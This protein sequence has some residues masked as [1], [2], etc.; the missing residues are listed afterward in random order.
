MNEQ[1]IKRVHYLARLLFLWA[2]LIAG[3][4]IQLQ[5]FQHDDYKRQA[6]NQQE[7]T[8]EVQAPRGKILDRE[9]QPLAMS[10]LADSVCVNPL[11]VPDLAVAAEIL[12]KTLKLDAAEL[13]EKM[14]LAAADQRG[15]LW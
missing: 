2:A 1:T 14:Q 10:I 12:S 4:L 13:L 3:R 15:F 7:K 6:I 5:I 8:V 9:R 11:R